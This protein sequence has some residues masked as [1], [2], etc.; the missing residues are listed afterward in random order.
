MTH[1]GLLDQGRIQACARIL[2]AHGDPGHERL[3]ERYLQ[4]LLAWNR[5]TNLV[6]RRL[7]PEQVQALVRAAFVVPPLLPG[8][9][10]ITVLDAGA[11]AGMIG[12]AA[13]VIRPDAEVIAVERRKLRA[14]FLEDAARTC[15][16][17]NWRIVHGELATLPRPTADA[18]IAQAL[19]P[20]ATALELLH[21]LVRP[22]GR[23]LIP[24]GSRIPELEPPPGFELHVLDPRAISPR[25]RGLV[26]VA[27]RA[28]SRPHASGPPSGSGLTT[29][30]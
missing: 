14:L 19:A 13:A 8:R 18:V 20:P 1:Q 4:R 11:G 29:A 23:I 26:L 25:A 12:F 15:K 17:R 21:P 24:T 9:P 16:L 2:E 30:G 3:I 28:G 27:V 22:A 5:R 6:S 10:G 7:Q